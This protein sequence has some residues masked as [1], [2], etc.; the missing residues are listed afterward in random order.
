MKVKLGLLLMI[1]GACSQAKAEPT[2]YQCYPA[3][4]A[5]ASVN[6]Y[7]IVEPETGEFMLFDGQG[8][9]INTAYWSNDHSY[10]DPK[11]HFVSNINGIRL[12]LHL[13]DAESNIFKF[14]MFKEG[15]DPAS[16]YCL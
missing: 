9:F 10:D 12:Y 11:N 6:Y 13:Q 8:I 2:H 16:S 1:M 4:E 5:G 14:V 3:D 7:M 15:Y